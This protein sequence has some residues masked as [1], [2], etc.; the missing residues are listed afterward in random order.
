[1]TDSKYPIDTD[2]N[3]LVINDELR[4][5][6]WVDTP[7][8]EGIEPDEFE[9]LDEGAF[10]LYDHDADAGVQI[11]AQDTTINDD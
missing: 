10:G 6:L 11:L 9:W 7:D 8:D 1:M 4:L 5:T 3:T 2:G